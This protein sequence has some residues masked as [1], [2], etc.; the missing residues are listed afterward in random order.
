MKKMIAFFV[1]IFLVLTFNCWAQFS[2]QLS[3]AK[4]VKEGGLLGGGYF[5]VY[6]DAFSIFGQ[7]RY[8]F[9]ADFDGGIKLGLLN[10]DPGGGF[11]ESK[12]GIIL[13]GDAKYQ[14]LKREA[15][16][17]VDCSFGLG[18]EYLSISDYSIFSFG[19]NL[20]GSYDFV[21]ES[22]KVITPYGRLNLRAQ[23]AEV[24][25]AGLEGD[26][27]FKVAFCLGTEIQLTPE[28]SMIAEL[29]IDDN[30]GI[31]GGVSYNIF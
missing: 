18:M 5:G 17:P 20:I 6:E 25:I 14:L 27:D 8:G 31:I 3:T 21:L 9:M 23:R 28:L 7:M 2:G 26:T 29:Q 1:V 15:K 13:A 4:T 10:L 16:D 24:T 19:G 22:K 11:G 12:T 30:V